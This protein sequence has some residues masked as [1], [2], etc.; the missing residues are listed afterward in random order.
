MEIAFAF[1]HQIFAYNTFQDMK[2]Y[3][4]KTLF[5]VGLVCF[6]SGCAERKDSDES[7]AE[8]LM[9]KMTLAEKIGQLCQF[10]P[11]NAVVTGPDGS[12]VDTRSVIKK[13]MCGSMLN[14]WNPDELIEYQKLAVDSSRLGIPILFGHD[15]IHGTRT[16]FPENL[17]ISCT[18][19]PELAEKVARISAAEAT[20]FGI[21]WTFSPMCDIS[22]DPRWGR[23]SEGSGE[24]PYLSGQLSAAMVRGYQGDDLSSESTIL[25]CVKHFAAYGGVE[26]GRDYNTVDM[27][28]MMFRD[29]YL[30]SYKAAL[31]AG[32]LSVMSSFNDFDGIPASGNRHLLTELLREELGF[33]G[34]VVS[35]YN[36]V[37]EL[38]NHGVAA[39]GKAAAELA[40]NAGLNM[41]MSSGLYYEY[42]EELV[43]EGRVSEKQIDRLCKEILTVKFKLGLFDDPFRYGGKGR[44]DNET[45][46]PEY[47]ESSREVAR[48]SMVLLKNKNGILPLDADMRIALIGP[49]AD[50]RSE[51]TGTWSA[52]VHPY[53]TVSFFEGLRERF[54]N[55]VCEKGCDFFDHIDGGISRAV[56]AARKSDIVLMTLGLPNTYSGEAASMTDIS[57]PA[58]QKELFETVK[59]TGKP[60]VIL[61]IT[62]RPMT[63][64]DESE[65]ADGLLV[66][67]HPGTMG[68]TALADVL[69]GDYNPSGRL[70]MTF[71]RCVG[72]IPIHYA[73]KN[74]GRPQVSP[75]SEA[76]YV[77]HYIDAPNEPLF[78]FGEGLS[79]TEFTYSDLEI[80]NPDAAL[81]ETVN[82]RVKVTNSGE[83]DGEEVVQLYLR[84]MIGSRTRPMRELKGFRKM[85]IEAGESVVAEFSITPEARS[86]FRADGTWGEEAGDFEVFLGH[87]SK[88]DLK[89]SF[90][91]R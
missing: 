12:P 88:A 85:C 75:N 60:I 13:G 89:G 59:S 15:L 29:C 49:A 74:T 7:R 86:F 45:C 80:V 52:F 91:I 57:L 33:N 8:E 6:I 51:M 17:G 32:A 22:Y 70:T 42:A 3:R 24:D 41:D 61:L 62:G 47:L 69:S 19:S 4:G 64:S 30:P 68:G 23:V 20:A 43:K 16:G 72:Q 40:L 46:L 90:K 10:V 81:G 53:K 31:E 66:T 35:D 9:S 79:Y 54:S 50:S 77:S 83:R 76:R 14:I 38:I 58:V 48:S 63:I 2:I 39:D 87:D 25:S 21:A 26:A 37:K 82:V 71:P 67:W 78:A 65:S 28:E 44:W 27:S 11:A 55:V 36:S 73:Y 84:D 18:W 34:F 5:L 56:A 1:L